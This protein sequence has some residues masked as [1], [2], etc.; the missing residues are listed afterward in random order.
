MLLSILIYEGYSQIGIADQACTPG[1]TDCPGATNVYPFMPSFCTT[2]PS[3]ECFAVMNHFVKQVDA[4]DYNGVTFNERC[5]FMS[6]KNH[7]VYSPY[8]H[9][10]LV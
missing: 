2:G 6:G 1:G 3:C 7:T 8:H 9:G 10:T 4:Y 5:M